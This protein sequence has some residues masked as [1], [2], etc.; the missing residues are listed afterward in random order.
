MYRTNKFFF[1][2]LIACPSFNSF[3]AENPQVNS[4]VAME[5][6]PFQSVDMAYV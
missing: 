2:L 1:S 3:F 4:S 6:F 5:S